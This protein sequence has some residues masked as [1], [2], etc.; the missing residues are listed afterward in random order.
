MY[1]A[2]RAPEAQPNYVTREEYQRLDRLLACTQ[3]HLLSV[4]RRFRRSLRSL[5]EWNDDLLVA[6]HRSMDSRTL[7][8]NLDRWAEIWKELG[9]SNAPATNMAFWDSSHEV[10]TSR[11]IREEARNFAFQTNWALWGNQGDLGWM[12]ANATDASR[13]PAQWQ[14]GF[15]G[16]HPPSYP[17]QVGGQQVELQ[18]V[19]PGYGDAGFGNQ[20]AMQAPLQGTPPYFGELQPTVE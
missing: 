16:Y 3:A 20:P 17:F 9:R 13:A 2:T 5:L 14:G 10:P 12:M 18:Y 6:A 8:S 7:K 1:P 15:G 4:E 11:R 19:G